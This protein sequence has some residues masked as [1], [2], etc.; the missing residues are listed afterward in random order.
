MRPRRLLLLGLLAAVSAS[1]A[2]EL[3]IQP[4]GVPGRCTVEQ[5]KKDWP[6]CEWE[7]GV[8]EGRV[9]IVDRNGAKAFRVDYAVGE[10]GPD[11]GGGGWRFPFGRC[12]DAELRYT[13]RFSKDFAW[14][15]GGKLPGLCGG[16]E[17]V[18]GGKPSD[19]TNGFS[20][21]LMWRADGRGEAYV[22]HKN[23]RGKYGDSFVFPETF[24][25]P[26]ETDIQ[27]RM[28]LRMNT[29]GARN[30][31]LRVWITTGHPSNEQLVVDR[32][33]LEW[34]NAATFGV[35]GIFFDAFHG[36]NDKTWAP[37]H[38]CWTEFSQIAVKRGAAK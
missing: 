27:V 5:W 10:I 15:K 4:S 11:K 12:E 32:T 24:R 25:F 26:T 20:A 18:S 36:G 37:P 30:G 34:R 19:G 13:L 29:S 31:T 38:P 9:S 17:N 14:V 7:D 35:D 28:N 23:Q 6:G 22:Y 33:D 8:A 21:R 1:A 2:D 3:H 16:P